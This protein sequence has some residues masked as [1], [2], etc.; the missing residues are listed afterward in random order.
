[1]FDEVFRRKVPGSSPWLTTACC[2]CSWAPAYMETSARP[3]LQIVYGGELTRPLPADEALDA[4]LA[5]N[6]VLRDVSLRCLAK[7]RQDP[8]K[9]GRKEMD[10]KKVFK[11]GT[12]KK[13][14]TQEERRGK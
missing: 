10:L 7:E 3:Q 5:L 9:R 13:L 14:H 12:V 4:G 6:A 1:M 8:A 2:C 11:I